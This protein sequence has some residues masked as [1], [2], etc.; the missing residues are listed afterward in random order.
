MATSA[1]TEYVQKAPQGD[2]TQKS[3]VIAVAIYAT[4][5][6]FL[7]FYYPMVPFCCLRIKETVPLNG[8]NGKNLKLISFGKPP[9]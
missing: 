2:R 1:K 4:S 8:G 7:F 9:F 5:V 6:A 3:N